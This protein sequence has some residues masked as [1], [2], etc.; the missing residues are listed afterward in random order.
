MNHTMIDIT[1]LGN[2]KI[3]DEVILLGKD[4]SQEITAQELTQKIGTINYGIVTRINP[5]LPRI[6]V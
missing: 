5:L 1:S 2:I 3:S 6:Y 4:T